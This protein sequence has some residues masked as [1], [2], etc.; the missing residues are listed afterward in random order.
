[1]SGN[2]MADGNQLL[3]QCQAAV[4]A[5]DGLDTN[6]VGFGAGYCLGQVS[7]VMD[8]VGAFA[9]DL[10]AEF[11]VCI[12]RPGI[13]YGQGVRIVVQY[14]KDHPKFLHLE[15]SILILKSFQSAYPCK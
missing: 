6:N 5:L 8:M 15:N 11:K 1:M 9:E 7:G 10:P 13:Q 3:T 14:L 4:R 2:A 12:P